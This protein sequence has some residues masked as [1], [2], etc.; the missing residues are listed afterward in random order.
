MTATSPPQ[1]EDKKERAPRTE[2]ELVIEE[3]EFLPPSPGRTSKLQANLEV[4][5]NEHPGKWMVAAKYDKAG[6]ASA[7]A[8]TLRAKFGPA[9]AN[10][11]SF[12]TRSIESGNRTA[13]FVNFDPSKIEPGKAEAWDR[14]R[15]EREAKRLEKKAEKEKSQAKKA[16]KADRK[17]NQ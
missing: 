3:M 11:W 2:A 16:E 12:A 7:A 5:K 6:A 10:G 14:V 8:S 9:E 13:L 4:I 15:A 1:T 17:A